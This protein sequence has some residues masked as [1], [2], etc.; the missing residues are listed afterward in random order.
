MAKKRKS[1]N[2]GLDEVDKTM[3]TTFCSAANSLSQLYTQAQNQQKLAFQAGERHGLEKMYQWVLRAQ[4]SGSRL[5]VTDIFG[6]LQH[7]LDY[8]GDEVSMSPAPQHHIPP[9]SQQQNQFPLISNQMSS[10]LASQAVGGQ[11][12]RTGLSEQNKNSVFSNALSSPV[13]RSL[14]PFHIAQG[15]YYHAS[16]ALPPGNGGRRAALS[17]EQDNASFQGVGPLTNS[18][19]TEVNAMN[20]LVSACQMYG[21]QG[22]QNREPNSYESDSTMDMNAEGPGQGF[23][24]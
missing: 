3:Y 11:G 1:E 24:Q 4:E 23:Y 15:G 16:N 18:Q 7:E 20:S 12:P 19:D 9:H 2:S 22:H 10:G 8:G 17:T 14:Q 5:T 6:Y 13:R 21:Q